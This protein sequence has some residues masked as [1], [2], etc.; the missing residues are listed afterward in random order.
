MKLNVK[1]I[2]KFMDVVHNCQGDVFLTDSTGG[3]DFSLNLKSELSLYIGV[4][5]L[6]SEHG[7]WLEIYADN[8]EDEM[9]LIKF[10]T[11]NC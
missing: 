4:S 2:D 9:K 11:E 7:D 6:L 8:Y 5:K 3:K 1:N 10:M